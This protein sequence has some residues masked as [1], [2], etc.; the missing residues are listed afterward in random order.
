MAAPEP[1][2]GRPTGRASSTRGENATRWSTSST[3]SRSPTPTA[4]W[5]MATPPTAGLGGGAEPP[6]AE[7]LDALPTRTGLVDRFAELF[8]AGASGTPSIRGHRL[9][10]LDRW[11][12]HE[13]AVLRCPQPRRRSEPRVLLDPHDLTGDATASLDWYAPSVDGRLVAFG[14]G[15]RR[16]AQH[17]GRA[18]RGDRRAAGRHDPLHAASVAGT[19]RPCV[20]RTAPPRPGCGG[21][22]RVQL[23]PHGLG[24]RAGRRLGTR[25]AGLVRPARQDRLAVGRAVRRPL[26]GHRGG[27][28]AGPGWTCT[29]STGRPATARP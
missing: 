12:E 13:Q 8:G 17:A 1:R 27:S 22:R 21:R 26:A 25:R 3:A 10:S 16:R 2:A 5:R 28:S 4:G 20:L 29:S 23:P 9:F 19:R 18:G 7:V 14:L 6:H 24:G 15:R 11:G